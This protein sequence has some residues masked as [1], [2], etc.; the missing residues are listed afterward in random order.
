MASATKLPPLKSVPRSKRTL[1][2]RK[3]SVESSVF[4][5]KGQEVVHSFHEED[6]HELSKSIMSGRSQH[7]RESLFSGSKEIDP[8]VDWKEAINQKDQQHADHE[9]FRSQATTGE[10]KEFLSKQDSAKGPKSTVANDQYL[11]D[12]VDEVDSQMGATPFNQLTNADLA[13]FGH[14]VKVIKTPRD[15]AAMQQ[16]VAGHITK[17]QQVPN[18]ANDV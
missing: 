3:D 1:K 4:M 17:T 8:V 15:G 12:A 5:Q 6:L 18:K 7:K 9:R 2:D 13:S 11:L 14:T 16:Q 10:I